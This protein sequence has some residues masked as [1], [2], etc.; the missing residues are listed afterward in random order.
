MKTKLFILALA[1]I[2]QFGCGGSG[3]GNLP[4]EVEA[5][6]TICRFAKRDSFLL[7]RPDSFFLTQKYPHQ[8]NQD[9]AEAS[10]FFA[11]N[12]V[13]R[14][15]LGLTP[16]AHSH[17]YREFVKEL[18]LTDGSTLRDHNFSFAQVL[19]LDSVAIEGSRDPLQVALDAI[20][21]DNF[22]IEW[23]EATSDSP[24]P[25]AEEP[26]LSFVML[27]NHPANF[28]T[29]DLDAAYARACEQVVS[30]ETQRLLEIGSPV[31]VTDIQRSLEVLE[32]GNS[33]ET[34]TL[35]V[36]IVDY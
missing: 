6:N 16:V 17:F 34:M 20:E 8:D 3:S 31:S 25:L 10:E 27:Y 19:F 5:Q 13:P 36:A 24:S 28:P 29:Q 23:P 30:K 35:R 26:F 9:L 32:V 7:K 2:S 22:P 15:A 33:R 4:L 11:P 12:E 18:A 21:Q 14:D 1:T